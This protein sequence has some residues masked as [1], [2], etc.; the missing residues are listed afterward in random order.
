[1]QHLPYWPIDALPALLASALASAVNLITR[2]I[3]KKRRQMIADHRRGYMPI[4]L[5]RGDAVQGHVVRS[6]A[7]RYSSCVAEA[8]GKLQPQHAV[9]R[10]HMLFALAHDCSSACPAHSLLRNRVLHRFAAGS[11]VISLLP[12]FFISV[13]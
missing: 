13:H 4:I 5:H 12:A 6:L 11:Q 7:F 8:A 10:L 2:R 1:M 3:N 9:T